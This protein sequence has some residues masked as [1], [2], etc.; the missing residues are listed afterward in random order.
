MP[1][2]PIDYWS[3]RTER[4]PRAELRQ[5]QL[6]K[7]QR[8]VAWATDRS[9]FWRRKLRGCHLESLDDLRRLPFLTKDELLADQA[10]NP[11]YG[12]AITCSPDLAIAYHHTSG[13]TGKAP[14]RVFATRRDW[15]WGADAWARA[16]YAFGVRASDVVYFPFGYGP[17]IGFWGA[18]Y[19]VQRIGAMTVPGGGQSSEHR[20]RQI[21]D[22]QT[23]VVVATPSYALRLAAVAVEMGL[24][25][26]RGTRVELLLHAGEPGASIPAT[27]QRIEQQSG[28]LAG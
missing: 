20:L 26:A 28:A 21:V 2:R 18:H 11:P 5:L 15:D 7:L 16:L 25:L 14:L 22:C 17:F 3:P 13:T 12:T 23:T 1:P 27:R 6:Y 24:D 4:M 19:A 8:L 9:P 10:A